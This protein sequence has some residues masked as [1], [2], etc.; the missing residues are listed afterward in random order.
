MIRPNP[1]QRAYLMLAVVMLLWAGNSI[2][3][4]AIRTE[5]PPFTLACLRW[6]VASLIFLPFALPHVRAE[7]LAIAK[8]W[9]PILLFG[10][11]GVAAFNA[12]LYSGLRYT[13]AS[14]GLLL[15]AAIPALVLLFDRLL[16]RTRPGWGDVLGMTLAVMGVALILFRGDMAAIAGLQFGRGDVLVMC[17][18]VCWALY[19][20]LLR[21]RPALHPSSF[22]IATF[23]IGAVTMAALATTEWRTIMRI[24][25]TPEVFAAVG[26][27]AIFPSV[28]AYAL[29]N[30]AVQ[31]LGA[32]KAGQAITLMPLFGAFLA[33][34]TLGEPLLPFH[35][36]GMTF[37]LGGILAS[38]I[39][40]PRR[41]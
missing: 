34:A 26:Y 18:V 31:T 8:A 21:L 9:K 12:F 20:T 33:A 36:L 40:I 3:A 5:V 16:F 6:S 28:I 14:N 38:A 15:Q 19:T 7:R 27:V 17:G 37:I 11:L 13:S 4:R 2:V 41:T 24:H 25:W 10:L 29:F 23:L 35:F 39:G 30:A 1:T 22:L 32:G